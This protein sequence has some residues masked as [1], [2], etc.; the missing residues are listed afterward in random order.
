MFDDYAVPKNQTPEKKSSLARIIIDSA[1]EADA[2]VNPAVPI[3]TPVSA[4]GHFDDSPRANL[5]WAVLSR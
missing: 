5:G 2:A 3:R 1:G 4:I